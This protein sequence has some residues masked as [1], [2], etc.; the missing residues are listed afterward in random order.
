[1]TALSVAHLPEPIHTVFTAS[2]MIRINFAGRFLLAIELW[3]AA[4]NGK[5]SPGRPQ[6]R[7]RSRR[8]IND[9]ATRGDERNRPH[10]SSRIR[11]SR[12]EQWSRNP[13]S[14][15]AG[16]SIRTDIK[17]EGINTASRDQ[18]APGSGSEDRAN[19][20]GRNRYG[21]EKFKPIDLSLIATNSL[22]SLGLNLPGP[23]F[24]ES[25]FRIP[26]E[27]VFK[28]SSIHIVS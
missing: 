11:S 4:D 20:K 28:R 10:S 27:L 23:S 14:L 19:S 15:D 9:T 6:A 17:T 22:Y 16:P 12:D 26:I 25:P 3:L 1:M 5:M 2:G 21:H 18:T 13:V 8:R 24:R 7:P